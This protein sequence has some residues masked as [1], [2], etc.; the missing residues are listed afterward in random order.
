MAL[1]G[2]ARFYQQVYELLPHEQ[3]SEKVLEDDSALDKWWTAFWAE[4]KREIAKA[5]GKKGPAKQR[6]AFNNVPMFKG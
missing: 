3:P 6:E 1:L 2:Y 4:K 5:M